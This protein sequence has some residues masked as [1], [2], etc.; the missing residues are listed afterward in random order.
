MVT[1]QKFRSQ[2]RRIKFRII[3]AGATF[4]LSIWFL[5]YAVQFLFCIPSLNEFNHF[6]GKTIVEKPC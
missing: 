5:S 1:T 4:G 6:N 3:L 2:I